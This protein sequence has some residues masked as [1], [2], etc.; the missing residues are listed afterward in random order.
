MNDERLNPENL[1]NNDS[2]INWVLRKEDSFVWNEFLRANP[3]KQALIERARQVVLELHEAEKNLPAALDEDQVWSRIES[4]MKD[5]ETSSMRTGKS[6][7]G[8]YWL[9]K[10]GSL[11]A[12]IGVILGAWNYYYG[13]KRITYKELIT[14]AEVENKLL[15]KI[16]TGETPMQISLG[17]GS[18]VTLGK[19]SKLSYPPN[20][21]KQKREVYL[22]GEAFFNVARDASKPFYVYANETVT[23]VLGTSFEIKAFENSKS[24]TVD[25]RTGRVSVYK[26]SGIQSMDPEVTG[27]V[28]LPNQKV[29]FD[30]DEQS[31]KKNLVDTP[32]PI[33]N[34]PAEYKKKFEDVQATDVLK[35]MEKIYGV[36]IIYDHELLSKCIVSTSLRSES[37][38]DNLDVLCKTIG[39]TYKEIDAQI[40]IESKGCAGE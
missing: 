25:V 10:A 14:H 31:L 22:S 11:V 5:E 9:K 33:A 34:L 3:D 18:V 1:L 2:F 17:D 21:Q 7:A 19:N 35:E 39:G 40:V 20:F 4:S 8:F 6:R 32:L 27:L 15:E 29:T 23:K 16:N 24:V 30:R 37:L 13:Q 28:L 36:R 12:A 38:Y 26:Q